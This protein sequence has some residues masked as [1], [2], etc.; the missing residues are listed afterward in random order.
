MKIYRVAKKEFVQ[1]LSGEGA[2][3]HGGRWN[4]KG[5]SMLYFSEHLSLCVLEMLTRIDFEFLNQ[6]FEFIEAEVA[7]KFIV[8]SAKVTSISES[9]RADPPLILSQDFGSKWLDSNSDLGLSVP[10]AVLPPEFNILINPN[11]KLISKLKITNS[12][13]LDLDPRLI[14]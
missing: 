14:K 12:G 7:G 11:H 10:S 3:I 8:S 4:K 9:W 13:K 5:R 2:R 6:D 1:D